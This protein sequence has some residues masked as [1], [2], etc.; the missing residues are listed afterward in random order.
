MKGIRININSTKRITKELDKFILDAGQWDDYLGEGDARVENWHQQGI[1][2]VNGGEIERGGWVIALG[3]LAC[4]GY[5]WM[6][7]ALCIAIR[8]TRRSA[9]ANNIEFSKLFP[10]MLFGWIKPVNYPLLL[11]FVLTVVVVTI[12]IIITINV[13]VVVVVVVV[14]I[15]WMLAL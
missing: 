3:V 14:V 9:C 8:R 2:V 13:V 5:W 15:E 6:W 4:A 10:T 11:L 12:I 1:Q 7:T